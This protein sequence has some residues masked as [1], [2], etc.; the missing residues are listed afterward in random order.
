MLR[1]AE[2][3][4]SPALDDFCKF[5]TKIMHFRH[6][7][8]K[9]QLQNLKQ[10]FDWRGTGPLGPLW[11]R[12]CAQGYNKQTCRPISTLTLLSAE[13]QAGKL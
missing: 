2:G 3:R 13:H 12:P 9:I 6:I 5:V 8:A 7:L 10:H 11:L 1:D 4:E